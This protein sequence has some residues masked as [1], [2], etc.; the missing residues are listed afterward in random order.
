MTL[1]RLILLLSVGLLGLWVLTLFSVSTASA[2]LPPR[3]TPGP[4]PVAITGQPGQ[5]ATI[6][7]QVPAAQANWW[8]T[9]QWQDAQKNWHTVTGWQGSFDAI[10]SG[11][12]SKLWWVAPVDLGKGPFRWTI[13]AAPGGQLLATSEAFNLPAQSKTKTVVTVSV[14]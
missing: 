8:T 11:A 9:V 12:G 14:P 10:K 13:S 1:K 3:P 4:T 6:E 2:A 7:L 5:G